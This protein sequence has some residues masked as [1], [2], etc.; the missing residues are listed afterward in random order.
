MPKE[1]VGERLYRNARSPRRESSILFERNVD[2]AANNQT[3]DH[4]NLSNGSSQLI[5]GHCKHD[6]GGNGVTTAEESN[7][8]D[9]GEYDPQRDYATQREYGIGEVIPQVDQ[10][11]W[12]S[13]SLSQSSFSVKGPTSIKEEVHRSFSVRDAA[14]EAV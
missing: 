4:H 5:N 14:V 3:I 10:A 7:I 8:N 6:G 12:S 2:A 9:D 11:S 1:P 13:S